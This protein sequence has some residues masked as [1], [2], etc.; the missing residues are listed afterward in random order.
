M[1]PQEP[2]TPQKN[3]APQP[4]HRTIQPL[5]STARPAPPQDREA[6]A[7]IMRSQI[8]KLYDNDPPHKQAINEIQAQQQVA[9]P[10][11]DTQTVYG[12]THGSPNSAS[13]PAAH[14]LEQYHTA[15]Q[16]YY[17][18][19]YERYYVQQVHAT[20]SQLAARA[21]AAATVP[22]ASTPA[23]DSE[24]VTPEQAISELRNDLLEKV[25][26]QAS[27][28]R[29][30]RHFMPVLSAL[31][32][33]LVFSVLQYNR[34]LVAQVYAYV[35]PGSINPQNIVLDPTTELKVSNDPRIVI[36]K[37]NVDAP[38]VYGLKSIAEAPVQKALEDGIVH[39]PIPGANSVPGQAGNTAL[40]GHSSNDVFDN[41]S[42]KFIFVQLDQLNKGDTFYLHYKG[43]R[44]TYS[45]TKKEIIEPT[46]I[47]KLTVKTSKPIATLITC[48]PPGTALK[49]LIVVGEQISP[50]PGK[51]TTA[52]VQ[53]SD[54]EPEKL[55][56]NA[57]TFLERLFG[58]Q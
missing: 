53:S 13:G 43:T 29:R 40:L 20:R 21:E 14:Q 50:D 47:N 38:V 51:A 54:K 48:T 23:S 18:Q 56:A 39:Y 25:R 42:Y 28:V 44:Y 30:S 32:V 9:Q 49:R 4:F 11:D 58:G 26:V 10:S 8:D 6:A 52:P 15:W 5:Q 45:V 34:V 57:P 55:P 24:S 27:K 7:E 31:I 46:E 36:P 19:Y 12:R 3:P 1:R 2:N 17:R 33:G 37:I 16:N 41:G 35:S 22:A